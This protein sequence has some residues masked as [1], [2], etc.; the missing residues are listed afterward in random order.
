[1]TSKDIRRIINKHPKPS[2]VAS[3]KLKQLAK[4]KEYLW[5]GLYFYVLTPAILVREIVPGL[6]PSWQLGI[7]LAV[8]KNMVFGQDYI[9][10]YGP[11][12]ILQIKYAL[13]ASKLWILLFELFRTCCILY[14]A[15]F[16]LR[17]LK[18]KLLPCLVFL[19]IIVL[20]NSP[21]VESTLTPVSLFCMIGFLNNRNF[22]LLS[23]GVIV[24]IISFYMKVNYGIIL[25][26]L[27]YV[28]MMIA[29]TKGLLSIKK[30]VAITI[31]HIAVTYFL[32]FLLNVNL[33]G[34]VQSSLHL[35]GSYNDAMYVPIA[36]SDKYLITAFIV[37]GLFFAGL[38]YC[39]KYYLRNLIALCGFGFTTLY[40]FLLF[41]NGYVRADQHVYLFFSS[42]PV[43]FGI[44]WVFAINDYKKV[45]GVLTLSALLISYSVY[46]WTPFFA[47]DFP[48][49]YQWIKDA[50][51][52]REYVKDIFTD[53]TFKSHPRKDLNDSGSIPQDYLDQ[54]KSASMDIIPWEIFQVYYNN[55]N[56]NPRPVAQ[57]YSAY[58]EYLDNKDYEKYISATAP[59]YIVYTNMTIDGRYP[60]W[61]E[62]IT[63]RGILTHYELVDKDSMF[64][65]RIPFDEKYYLQKYPDIRDAVSRG[66]FRSGHEHFV[67]Y[68]RQENRFAS[69]QMEGM[70][71]NNV[72]VLLKK[73]KHSRKMNIVEETNIK[74][75]MNKKYDISSTD[76]LQYLFADV[77]YDWKGKLRGIFFQ[78]PPLEVIVTFQ[79]N[80][81]ARFRAVVPIVK[82]G[83][84]INRQV[85]NTLE[86]GMFFS[87]DGKLNDRITSIRFVAESGFEQEINAVV[88]EI[89][90]S[91]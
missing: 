61:D 31:G 90:L 38:I 12:G 82:T 87:K 54:I 68:G 67:Q 15:Q 43:V 7:N 60:F 36:L 65:T 29:L 66:Q 50:V 49:R 85:L 8:Q 6:D 39:H 58:D 16:I 28:T 89:T 64:N 76:N 40:L 52:K 2:N 45:W 79:G 46:L 51:N 44:T 33:I 25:F 22:I 73:R 77:Q 57:S 4:V 3:G 75:E 70:I 69:L 24:S 26:A 20:L 10:T 71:R 5:L 17:P 18:Y 30:A 32:S 35:I 47:I 59:E 78:P 21:V 19:L 41:K 63:K 56:Y 34:Y 42:V 84:L 80:S 74:M 91:E 9:F 62:S 1:M 48:E 23:I 55:L 81:M 83:I 11:L 53:V 37:V 72:Y 14:V 88:K 86:A 27:L 13:A